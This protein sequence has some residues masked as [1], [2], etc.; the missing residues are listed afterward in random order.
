MN[1][2]LSELR[3]AQG[4]TAQPA[5]AEGDIEM[6]T[7]KGAFA[8]PKFMEEFFSDVEAVKVGSNLGSRS[9]PGNLMYTGI[10]WC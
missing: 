1:D 3:R 8:Q 10:I 4:V 6:G 7:T 5:M 9:W 2:R